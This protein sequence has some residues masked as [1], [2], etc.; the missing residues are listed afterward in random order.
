MPWTLYR[1]FLKDVIKVLLLATLVLVVLMSFGAAIKPLTDGLLGPDGLVRFVFY[2]TPTFLGFV[3][4]FAGA[5]AATLVFSRLASD[6]EITACSASGISYASVLFPVTVLGLALTMGLFYLSNWVVPRFYDATAAVIEKDIT[7]AIITTIQKGQPVTLDDVSNSVLYA[8]HAR[9]EPP[10]VVEEGHVQPTRRIVLNRVVFAQRG[11]DG[12]LR[13]DYTAERADVFLYHQLAQ[14]YALVV[15]RNFT[16]YDATLGQF[17]ARAAHIAE[18]ALPPVRLRS[19]L[20][21]N[22]KFLS[23]PEIRKLH[24]NPERFDRV[25]DLKHKLARAIAAERL[26]Q[27]IEGSVD[28]SQGNGGAALL[29][30]P[31]RAEQY[32]VT[33]PVVRRTPVGLRLQGSAERPVRIEY[34]YRGEVARIITAPSAII[35]VE[36]GEIEQE[37]LIITRMTEA[38]VTDPRIP[39]VSAEHREFE[40]P[41]CRWPQRI[42]AALLESITLDELTREAAN[43]NLRGA[44]DIRE[45][46]FELGRERVKLERRIYAQ[47]HERAASAVACP[48]LLLLGAVL[49]MKLRNSQSLVVFFWSCILAF[50]TVIIINAGKHMA[51]DAAFALYAGLILLWSGNMLLAVVVGAAYCVLARN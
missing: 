27:A 5:F 24:A 46:A 11:D 26:M 44:R 29:Q 1:Y 23:L 28:A 12:R 37:P 4:P 25:R 17:D 41:R 19:P 15:L 39:G 43:P 7:R 14:S 10:P 48:L 31:R 18:L 9:E 32:R 13:G 38:V 20:R 3:L 8:D 36:P 42:T 35:T 30:G 45:A 2:S 21:D 34:V 49:S 50:I 40:L 22:P 47:L 6:N 33:A 16:Q 51:E